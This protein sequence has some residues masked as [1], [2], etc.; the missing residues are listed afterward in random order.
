VTPH[1]PEPQ[2]EAIYQLAALDRLNGNA[3]ISARVMQSSFGARPKAGCPRGASTSMTN[4]RAC[5]EKFGE[6]V[7]NI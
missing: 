5:G 1:A 2:A 7:S 4:A 6:R 3:G